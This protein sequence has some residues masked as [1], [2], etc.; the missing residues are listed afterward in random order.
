MNFILNK[1]VTFKSNAD[2]KSALVKYFVLAAIVLGLSYGGIW[3]LNGVAGI[4]LAVAK[5]ITDVLLWILNFAVQ[6]A[7]VFKPKGEENVR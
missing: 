7:Y 2:T 1:R 4:P 3:V 5:P 6:R